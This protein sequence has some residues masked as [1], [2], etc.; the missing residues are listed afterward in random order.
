VQFA[1]GEYGLGYG[2][3]GETRVEHRRAVLFVNG[4]WALAFDRL[5]GEGEHLLESRFVFNALPWRETDRGV[6]TTTGTGD[7]DVRAAWPE[8]LAKEVACGREA[9]FAGWVIRGLYGK[10]PAPRLTFSARARLPALWV[11]LLA[12]FR[13]EAE[14]PEVAVE[15]SGD[16]L[17][18]RIRTPRS[19]AE[20]AVREEPFEVAFRNEAVE[21]EAAAGA[22]G[23]FRFRE[24]G[25]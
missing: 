7:L 18:L 6:R 17:L 4:A 3:R 9:P 8:G 12:P 13:E 11:T 1:A 22:D 10:A 15:K 16:R 5:L 20:V 2:D 24:E 14:I 19:T 23:R 21:F 25:R